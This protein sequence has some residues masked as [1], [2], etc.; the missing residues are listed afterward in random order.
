MEDNSFEQQP[1]DQEQ[2]EAAMLEQECD[3]DF[4]KL[5]QKREAKR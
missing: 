4:E 2:D 5:E 1:E 3:K